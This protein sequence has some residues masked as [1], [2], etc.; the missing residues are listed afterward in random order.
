MS[1]LL[2]LNTHTY[3]HNDN[4]KERQMQSDTCFWKITRQVKPD[5]LAKDN[6]SRK[7]LAEMS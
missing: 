7:N 2:Q 3:T 6:F 1:I 5:S 4:K